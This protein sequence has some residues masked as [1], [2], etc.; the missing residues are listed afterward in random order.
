MSTAVRI[1][2][3]AATLALVAGLT[4]TVIAILLIDHVLAA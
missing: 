1:R 2:L 4:A 3:L